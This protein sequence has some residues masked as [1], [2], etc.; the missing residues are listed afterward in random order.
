MVKVILERSE[1][2][3]WGLLVEIPFYTLSEASLPRISGDNGVEPQ[4]ESL[5]SQP[6]PNVCHLSLMMCT[7]RNHV[8][9]QKLGQ[10]WPEA[11]DLL[12]I[13]GLL[14]LQGVKSREG[15]GRRS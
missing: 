3:I 14:G 4:D 10:S 7:I 15:N 11:G 13:R 5:A 9:G 2:V 12:R 6:F 8:E 1:R